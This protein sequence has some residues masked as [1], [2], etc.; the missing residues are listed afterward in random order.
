M[1]TAIRIEG[2]AREAAQG[3]RASLPCSLAPVFRNVPQ[4]DG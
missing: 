4:A 3:Q 2:E 1:L